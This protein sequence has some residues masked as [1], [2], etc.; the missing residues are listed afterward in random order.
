[1]A[2]A[3]VA[4]MAGGLLVPDTAMAAPAKP[5]LTLTY[6]P[7]ETQ[8]HMRGIRWL[9]RR[10]GRYNATSLSMPAIGS[11]A[12]HPVP[13]DKV[14]GWPKGET[15]TPLPAAAYGW[16]PRDHYANDTSWN[17]WPQGITTYYDATGRNSTRMMVS[18][19]DKNYV[20]GARIALID[21]RA[22]NPRYQYIKLVT[23]K[24]QGRG[25][26]WEVDPNL[27]A[28]GLAWYRNRLYVTDSEQNALLVF[29]TDDI[30]R[31]NDPHAP[32]ALPLSR[33]YKADANE[34]NL[35][36][37]Q[38]AVDRT[39]LASPFRRTTLIVN[40]FE[41][42]GQSQSIGRWSFAYGPSGSLITEGKTATAADVYTIHRG[43]GIPANRGIQGAV[44]VRNTMYLSVSRGANH[45]YLSTA[46]LGTNQ[47]GTAKV[48]WQV[49][50]GPEDLSYDGRNGWMWG[51]G[52]HYGYRNVYAMKV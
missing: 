42:A 43:S 14:P 1:M 22:A 27:H 48:K 10:Y 37:S 36:F 16:A 17:W 45:G 5:K 39:S 20:Q 52:E 26:T 24:P 4:A 13:V 44:T 2:A 15:E 8:A 50:R 9:T 51:L 40:G 35:K 31:I 32:W 21:R 25:Y 49:P 47:E 7:A 23:A 38:V 34:A 41:R 28:G 6:E 3:P 19:Y 12:F 29:N 46:L 11:W 33:T 18:W 30:F